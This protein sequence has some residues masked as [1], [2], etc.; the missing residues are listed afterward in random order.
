METI[1]TEK[2]TE[3]LGELSARKVGKVDIVVPSSSLSMGVSGKVAIRRSSLDSVY[4]Y[5]LAPTD[6]AHTQLA[7]KLGI[8]KSYYDRMRVEQPE[9]LARNVNVWL[10]VVQ[11]L[12]LVRGWN[13]EMIAFLS[14][15]YRAIDNYDVADA[16]VK[17]AYKLTDNIVMT[18]AYVTDRVMDFQLV[19]PAITY[20]P[21]PG[22][23]YHPGINV[24]NS[25]V[26]YSRFMVEPFLWRT[27]CRNGLVL[28]FKD[29][30]RVHLGGRI[31][32]GDYWSYKTRQYENLLLLSEVEDMV[33]YVFSNEFKNEVGERFK[34]LKAENLPPKIIDAS[35]K[36]LNLTEEEGKDIYGRIDG[37]TRYDFIQ[38]I[39]NKANDYL[40]DKKNP[41]RGYELQVVGGKLVTD[42]E[43]WKK[44]ETNAEKL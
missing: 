7:E 4:D 8:P 14:N 24:R 26:G 13:G 34:T 3:F 27:M 40:N 9:L 37:N 11:T 18:K 32:E 25:E 10:G 42:R 29:I 21:M 28:G 22:D 44:I 38:A 33:Q 15:R 2:A 36:I 43:L 1:L 23:E 5:E 19:S 17:T 16:V 12:N 31:G 39:T 6:W 41:E 20:M 30:S 35:L